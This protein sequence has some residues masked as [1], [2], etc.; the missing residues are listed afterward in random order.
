MREKYLDFKRL[1]KI[2]FEKQYEKKI[3]SSGKLLSQY[4]K[5]KDGKKERE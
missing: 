4:G 1:K 3:F 5:L 2:S